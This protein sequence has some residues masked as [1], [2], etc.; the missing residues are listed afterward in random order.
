MYNLL[1]P[2][3]AAR[4]FRRCRVRGFPARPATLAGL[5]LLALAAGVP[6]FGTSAGAAHAPSG[7]AA[8][9]LP[10]AAPGHCTYVPANDPE[11]LPCEVAVHD[12]VPRSGDRLRVVTF[13]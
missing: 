5:A 11:A 2:A 4:R 1:R 10:A 7:A 13:N 3:P 8:A 12:P 6:A 9:S